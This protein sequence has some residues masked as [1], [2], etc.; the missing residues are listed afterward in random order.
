MTG[1]FIMK[2]F[3]ETNALLVRFVELA[4]PR[5]FRPVLC[6]DELLLEIARIQGQRKGVGNGG[7]SPYNERD[8]NLMNPQR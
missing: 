6:C 2:S 1:L 4:D 5:L 7:Q 8:G 3:S